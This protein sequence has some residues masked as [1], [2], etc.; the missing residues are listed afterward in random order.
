[1]TLLLGGFLVIHSFLFSPIQDVSV[2]KALSWAV[3]A[4]TLFGA[5]SGLSNSEQKLVSGQVFGGLIVVLLCS[6]PLLGT[7]LGYLRNGSGFQGILGHPQAFGPTMA[8]LGTWAGS[9]MLAESKPRWWVVGVF[10]LCVLFVILSEA[11]TA[12]V[13]MLLGISLAGVTGSSVA[14]KPLKRFLPGLLNPRLYMVLACLGLAAI[15]AGSTLTDRLDSYIAKRG[16]E[17]SLIGAYERSRGPLMD[18]MIG[19]IESHPITGIGF[20]IASVPGDIK[21]IRDPIIGLPIS[22][23]VEKGVLPLAILEEIGILGFCLVALWLWVLIRRAARRGGMVPL[24][25]FFVVLLINMGESVLFSPGGMGLLSLV[26]IGWAV[27]QRKYD[28]AGRAIA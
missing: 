5:W 28:A 6:V 2:M 17:S 20:G 7:S 15:I 4:A 14:Q 1:M 12:G 16:G 23:A 11:R 10:G 19:N 13:A 9:Q 3:A 26:L 27:T 8:L 22:A 18:Q 24:A 25:V 21:V